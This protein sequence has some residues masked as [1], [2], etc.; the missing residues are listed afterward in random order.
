[1]GDGLCSGL[2]VARVAEELFGTS[3][4]RYY[5]PTAHSVLAGWLCIRSQLPR[6]FRHD[7]PLLTVMSGLPCDPALRVRVD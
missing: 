3:T 4:R 5:E 7:A 6:W 1:M 2:L